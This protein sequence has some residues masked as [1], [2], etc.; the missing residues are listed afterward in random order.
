[1][2][3]VRSS[4]WTPRRSHKLWPKPPGQQKFSFAPNISNQ[5]YIAPPPPPPLKKA[6]VVVDNRIHAH[7]LE[8]TAAGLK[9]EAEALEGA[10]ESAP[11]LKVQLGLLLLSKEDYIKQILKDWDTKGKGEFLKGE[12]RLNL[13]NTGLNATSAEADDLFDSW[14]DDKGG[15]L[16]LKELKAALLKVQTSAK[17]WQSKPNPRLEKSRALRKRAKLAEDGAE[18]TAQADRMDDELQALT[19]S[20]NSRADVQ[21][22]AL[23]SRRRIKPGAVVTHWA[24]S[25]GEHAGEL[26]KK[27]FRV[28]VQ[29]LGLISQ[30]PHAITSADIDKVFETF[31]SDGGGYMDADEAKEMVKGLQKIAEEAEHERWVK[32]R[33][34]E[35]M[36]AIASKKAMLAHQPLPEADVVAAPEEEKPKPKSPAKPKEGGKKKRE[37]EGASPAATGKAGGAPAAGEAAGAPAGGAPAASGAAATAGGSK[38]Q[39]VAAEVDGGGSPSLGLSQ[40]LPLPL[41]AVK[42]T[43][44]ALFSSDRSKRAAKSDAKKAKSEAEAKLASNSQKAVLRIR[45]LPLLRAFNSWK[46]TVDNQRSAMGQLSGVSKVFKSPLVYRAFITWQ[47]YSDGHAHALRVIA[48]ALRHWSNHSEGSVT[49]TWQ[50][51]TEERMRAKDLHRTA[52]QAA[53]KFAVPKLVSALQ[54]WKAVQGDAK[55][56]SALAPRSGDVCQALSRCCRGSADLTA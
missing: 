29:Q 38:A 45:N 32:T 40:K 37:A 51:Y 5:P 4:V 3:V 34:A 11:S 14:D 56:A 25:K 33:E 55:L 42:K 35:K 39:E 26:S 10:T 53:A 12:F 18:A 54:Q 2:V 19:D 27:E 30:G 9:A 49:R 52:L 17:Q 43:I 1:M 50:A 22:G 46:Q 41:D 8:E 15:S 7:E 48:N 28:A 23:L 24:H 36:R 47:F 16:D 21:L 31:D 13:R 20:L 44:D 6:L